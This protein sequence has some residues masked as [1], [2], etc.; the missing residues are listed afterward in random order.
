MVVGTLFIFEKTRE[1]EQLVV[2]EFWGISST[3]KIFLFNGMKY[4]TKSVSF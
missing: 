4:D 2:Y 3:F 1:V